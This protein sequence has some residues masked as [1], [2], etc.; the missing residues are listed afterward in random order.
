MMQSPALVRAAVPAIGM[1][2]SG[3][4]AT[5]VCLALLVD[6][7]RQRAGVSSTTT[8]SIELGFIRCTIKPQ[9]FPFHKARSHK[10]G[11]F[12]RNLWP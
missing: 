10:L 1:S 6:D 12:L 5:R 3:R 7:A 4:I 9:L 8:A 11:R 2:S